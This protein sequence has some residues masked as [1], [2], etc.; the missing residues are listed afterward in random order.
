MKKR[1]ASKPPKL[2]PLHSWKDPEDYFDQ[3]DKGIIHPA[4]SV[5][6]APPTGQSLHPALHFEPGFTSVGILDAA[7]KPLLVT[8]LGEGKPT[9]ASPAMTDDDDWR[10]GSRLIHPAPMPYARFNGRWAEADVKSFCADGVSAGFADFLD[11]LRDEL[12][13][14]VE[15]PRPEHASLIACW[16]AGTYF[17]PLFKTFPRLNLNGRKASGT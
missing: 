16:I 6:I 7:G 5:L 17:S 12:T 14:L 15:F 10:L 9:S 4:P 1:P 3:A 11:G 8:R 2:T 13:R